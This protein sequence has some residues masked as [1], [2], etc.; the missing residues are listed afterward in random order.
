MTHFLTDYPDLC[1]FEPRCDNGGDDEE[2]KNGHH[3]GDTSRRPCSAEPTSSSSSSSSSL[4][5]KRQSSTP[6]ITGT[7]FLLPLLKLKDLT[8]KQDTT[9]CNPAI[10]SHSTESKDKFSDVTMINIEPTSSSMAIN[11]FD[12]DKYPSSNS[13]QLAAAAGEG[14]SNESVAGKS[15]AN[16]KDPINIY[17]TLYL[18]NAEHAADLETLRR[19]NIRYVLN[20]TSDLPNRF[21]NCKISDGEESFKYLRIPIVDNV[22]QNL[23]A[24]FPVANE[25]IGKWKCLFF[26]KEV[27]MDGQARPGGVGVISLKGSPFWLETTKN[28][29]LFSARS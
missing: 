22:S 27:S 1:V 24:Y 28:E 17:A 25:F 12:Y 7:P 26:G 23:A 10:T 8:L 3:D 6:L 11:Q 21:E 2:L 13:K 19:Y 9:S 20:V 5:S 16:D 15:S 14:C 18:G 29:G 4:L